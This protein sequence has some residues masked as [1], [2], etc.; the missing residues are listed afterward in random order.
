[1]PFDTADVIALGPA[2]FWIIDPA[3]MAEDEDGTGSVEA[4]DAVGLLED[5]SG[6]DLHLAQATPG[7]RPIFRSSGGF[8]WLEADATDDNLRTVSGSMSQPFTRVSAWRRLSSADGSLWGG[9]AGGAGQLFIS[10]G[11]LRIFSGTE[12][13]AGAAPANGVDFVAV[14]VFNGASSRIAINLAAG[15]TGNA[16]ATG[17]SGLQMFGIA[18][19]AGPAAR[20][21]GGVYFA[22]VVG[23]DVLLDLIGFF[24]ARQPSNPLGIGVGDAAGVAAVAGVGMALRSGAGSA[25]G[26][27][28]V[29]GAG[30][31][32]VPTSVGV[33]AGLSV[34]SAPGKAATKLSR[35][36][37]EPGLVIERKTLLVQ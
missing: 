6:N 18:T 29:A 28:T 4:D 11:D 14:E 33:A 16:G 21:Y 31:F 35:I 8:T 22:G 1:M 9:S 37:V 27:A 26:L 32:E 36:V 12:L 5:L 19:S 23:D 10:G 13:S 20:C 7:E 30:A 24:A 3:S 25:A 34:V 2:A 15:A 17:T